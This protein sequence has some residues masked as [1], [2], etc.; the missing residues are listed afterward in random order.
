MN[1]EVWAPVGIRL[2]WMVGLVVA[3]YGGLVLLGGGQR[4]TDRLSRLVIDGLFPAMVVSSLARSFDRGDVGAVLEMGFAA[5]VM[6][7]MAGLVG[8]WRWFYR[9]WPGEPR[10]ALFCVM[11]PNWIFLPL[12]MVGPLH[13]EVGVQAVI[14]FNIPMQVLLWTVGVWFLRGTLRGGH[15]MRSLVVNPGM[16]ATGVGMGLGWMWGD[17]EGG[18]MPRLIEGV[19]EAGSW[20]GSITVP[21]S[22]IALGC[23]IAALRDAG[24]MSKRG[25]AW[26][27]T[28][29]L[30][31]APLMFG[32]AI[33]GVA[34]AS[35]WFGDRE[36]R[37]ILYLIA[38][39]P[40]GVSVP[41]FL[42]RFGRDAGLGARAVVVSTMVSLVTAIPMLMLLE[43]VDRLLLPF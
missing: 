27:V 11:L 33:M 8:W 5:V 30:L 26:I 6:L 2:A 17:G 41:L 1:V 7:G 19:V 22:L 36:M 32:L 39:M 38:V 37:G 9:S 28:I 10:S 25:M 20:V 4:F 16:L 42:A 13:G 43:L 31:A 15:S 3:G 14:L 24:R 29:R 18:G 35:P 12:A 34:M 21:V 23:Q 40:I